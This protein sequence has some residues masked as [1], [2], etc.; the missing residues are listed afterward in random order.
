MEEHRMAAKTKQQDDAVLNA[1]AK[2]HAVAVLLGH[3]G[4]NCTGLAHCAD[5]EDSVAITGAALLVL[6]VEIQWRALHFGEAAK[7]VSIG[8]GVA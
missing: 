8:H 2:L 6:D 1:C 3:L 4:E 7:P 5:V